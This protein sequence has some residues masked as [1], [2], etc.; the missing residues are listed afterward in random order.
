MGKIKASRNLRSV[1]EE[2]VGRKIGSL[3]LL[4]SYWVTQDAMHKWFECV[5]VDPMHKTIRNDSRINWICN[6]A[7]KH[8]EM[9]G[10][11]SAGRKARG[12]HRRGKSATKIRGSRRGNWKKRQMLQLR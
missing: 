4:N 8:R 5:M 7:H 9:R 3:R 11:T 6:P 2:R 1:A 10:L 12:L